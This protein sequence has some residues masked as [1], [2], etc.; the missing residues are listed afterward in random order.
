MTSTRVTPDAQ[1]AVVAVKRPD[2]LQPQSGKLRHLGIHGAR[3][4]GKT[5]YLACL[6]GQRATEQ[7]AVA[8]SDDH[9]IDHLLAAWKVLERGEVPDATAL[10]LPTEVHM[11]LHSDGLAWNVTTRDYAGALVQRS[12]TGVPE[13]KEE[14]KQW[15]G[16]CH[17]ILLFVNID[18][19]ADARDSAIKERH[20]ELDLLIT[21]LKKL[22]PDGNMIGRPLALLLTKW[23]AQGEP[24]HDPARER[25]RAMQYL[26]SRPALK[27]IA[28]ALQ[29]CGD[30]VG[31][32]P[33][34]AFG[35]HREGNKPPLSGPRPVGLHD[36]LVWAVQKADEMLLERAKRDAERIG[37]P[38]LWWWQR[39]YSSAVRCFRSLVEEQGVNKGP[40]YEKAREELQAWRTKLYKQRALKGVAA[41][42]A[43]LALITSG[44]LLYDKWGHQSALAKLA[45]AGALPGDVRDECEHY[46]AY[47]NPVARWTGHR[48][49]IDRRWQDYR[50]S[51]EEQ[52]YAALDAYRRE[53][54]ADEGAGKCCDRAK[55]FRARWPGSSHAPTV[56]GWERD[57]RARFEQHQANIR[58]ESEY[59]GLR[60]TL[61]RLGNKYA[62]CVA[63]CDGFLQ[64]FPRAQYPK[65]VSRIDDVRKERAGFEKARDDRDWEEVINYKQQNPQNFDEIIHRAKEYANKPAAPYRTEAQE[66]IT[67][68]EIG[69]DSAEYNKV[70]HATG[71]AENAASIVAAE[72]AARWY[73]K[74]NHP[75]KRGEEAVKRWLAWVEGFRDEKDYYFTIKSLY[76]PSGSDL[77]HGD[78]NTKVYGRFGE[79]SFDTGWGF[80]GNNP[81]IGQEIG[82]VRFK[83]GEPVTV[84][85]TVE[86]HRWFPRFNNTASGKVE[87]DRFPLGRVSRPFIVT[88]D[89]QKSVEIRLAC[90][91]AVPPTLGPYPE[92]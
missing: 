39:R 68:T 32:F 60:K 46:L 61:G 52:E 14:V 15:L 40:T 28:D 56:E 4:T 18:A 59:Q 73:M 71:G 74:S 44:L 33:V 66:L 13:L 86:K 36:P 82:P 25:Q 78:N 42:V 24:S 63:E 76:I 26:Q 37:G 16:S 65:M 57:D 6:Y 5:C 64:R 3:G 9:S 83:W 43:V 35:S 87:N 1:A 81:Q 91:A 45:D 17:A 31:V 92:K 12:E 62:E 53:N 38:R 80:N 89:N 8:F 21:E 34:S 75:R 41:L 70:L 29:N 30:R 11:G 50:E 85:F 54:S 22:S 72:A 55:D 2:T 90:P 88:C 19:R 69:W 84:E 7:A 49:D 77:D 79:R 51:R 48:E 27:Q 23:D 47:W 10:T 67:S 58:L 20:D